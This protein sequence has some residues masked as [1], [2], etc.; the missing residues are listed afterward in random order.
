MQGDE[1]MDAYSSF[2]QVYDAFM[3]NIPYQ[4]GADY[5]HRLLSMNGIPDGLLAE[6]G[7]GTG[8]LTE[9]MAGYGYDMIGIDNSPD[10]LELAQEKRIHSQHDILYLLQDMR[11]FELYGTVRGMIS[12]NY[13]TEPKELLTVFQLVNNYLDPKGCFIFDFHTPHYYRDELG[14]STI[15]EDRDSM[16]FIWD[17]Y[18]DEA[19]GIHE[20]LLSLFLETES[21]LYRKFQE[22]HYQRGYELEEIKKLL[23][24]A[25]MTFLAAYDEFSLDAP[26]ELSTR[27]HVV[28]QECGK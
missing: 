26:T 1:K 9:L 6:L 28:A 5:I 14:M 17:N 12:V 20:Y 13:I 11:E 19:S 15:A 2:A 3:D 7:C 25:G 21:G 22:E 10:M 27:I 4:K 24:Q 8:T 18:Y 23:T 16:S